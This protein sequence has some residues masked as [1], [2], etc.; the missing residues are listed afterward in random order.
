MEEARQG[1]DAATL[2]V[3]IEAARLLTHAQLKGLGVH[4]GQAQPQVTMPSHPPM[5]MV[6]ELHIEVG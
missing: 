2:E 4:A 1:R 6:V 5:V 3:V